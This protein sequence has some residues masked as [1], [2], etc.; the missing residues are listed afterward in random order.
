MKNNWDIKAGH[1]EA[2]DLS[3]AGQDTYIVLDGLKAASYVPCKL[4]LAAVLV[5]T[6]KCK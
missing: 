1:F 4:M 2:A 5:M 6:D 3:S